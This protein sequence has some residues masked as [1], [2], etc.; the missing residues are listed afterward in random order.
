MMGQYA[1]PEHLRDADLDNITAGNAG[2]EFV[3]PDVCK[4]PGPPAPPV[5]IPY[6]NLAQGSERKTDRSK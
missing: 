3:F 5:P 2:S 6:P 4:F 1:E